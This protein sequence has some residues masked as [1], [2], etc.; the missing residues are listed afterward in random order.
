MSSPAQRRPAASDSDLQAALNLYEIHGNY[1]VAARAAG[2]PRKTFENRVAAAQAKGMKPGQVTETEE[3][4]LTIQELRDRNRELEGQIRAMR[5]DEVT[6]RAVRQTILNLAETPPPV[7]K[8]VIKHKALGKSAGVPML[9]LSDWHYA[10]V[11]DPAQVNGQNAY[12][13]AI[14]R[15][16]IRLLAEKTVK[17]AKKHMVGT[18]YP[19]IVISVEGDLLSGDI[20]DELTAT[21]ELPLMP[22]FIELHGLFRWFLDVMLAEF[23]R[24]FV[25][26]VPGNH[27]RTTIK[28]IYKGRNYS[29]FDWLLGCFLEMHYKGN[30]RITFSV[31]LSVD[32]HFEVA[33]VRVLATHGDCLGVKGGDGIIGIL[34]PLARGHVKTRGQAQ[35]EGQP[36]DLLSVGHFHTYLP[37]PRAYANGSLIGYNEYARA[38]LRVDPERPSQTLLFIHPDEGVTTAWPIYLAPRPQQ[39]TTAWV[40]WPR[41]G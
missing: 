18:D 13:T 17:L 30:E 39:S 1:S 26:W 25:S 14:A 37:L 10:E 27:G 38:K 41:A 19:G 32:S 9:K 34:G 11:V 22:A 40:S 23:G 6:A 4:R 35:A 7:P 21:N 31:P 20:H 15:E 2:L 33:G 28:P 3:F 8:W 29:N 24:V 16:R 12:S 5:R 36:F